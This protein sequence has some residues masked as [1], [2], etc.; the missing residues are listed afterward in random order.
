MSRDDLKRQIACRNG[1][2]RDVNFGSGSALHGVALP[3]HEVAG[4]MGPAIVTDR[5][6][7]IGNQARSN[8]SAF[9]TLAHAATKSR[10]NAA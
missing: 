4:P 3:E 8:R 1:Q 9:I 7:L 2:I 5:L 6:W 10:T